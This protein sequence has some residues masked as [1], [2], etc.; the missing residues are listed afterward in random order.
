MSGNRWR[1]AIL[2]AIPLV[3][4][5][6]LG[7]CL[8][9][10]VPTEPLTVETD[11]L[12]GVEQA[13]ALIVFLPGS[14]DRPRDLIRQGFVEQL[15]RRA[16]DADVVM[17]DLHV[18]YYTN[19][20]FTQR[21]Q[22]DVIEPA[23]A[24]G[25]RRIWLAGI[26]LGGFGALMYARRNP[27]SIEGIIA[28]APYVANNNV[29]EEVR[30]AGGVLNWNVPI[31]DGDWQRDLV[32]WLKTYRDDRTRPQLYVGYGTED[33]YRQFNQAFGAIFEV[34]RLRAAPGGHDWPPWQQLWGEF[35]DLAPLPRR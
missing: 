20:S 9:W 25:Y 23:R 13:Q 4:I 6:T 1:R 7:G 3:V 14:R 30:A 16:I 12:T 22:L 10:R 34:G 11:R 31:A 19:N 24:R 2:A 35:L 17:P 8:G 32:N 29:L 27:G 15:R 5:A 33:G 18:G 28:L 26:S 21:L